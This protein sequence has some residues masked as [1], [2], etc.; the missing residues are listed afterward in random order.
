M[1]AENPTAPHRVTRLSVSVEKSGSAYVSVPFEVPKAAT[2]FDLRY[3]YPKSDNCIIDLGLGDPDLTDFPSKQGLVGWSGG[4]RSAVFIAM[5]DASPGYA[6]GLR[7][8]TWQV[9]LG[10]YR[11]PDHPVT[12]EIEITF[13]PAPREE[14]NRPARPKIAS[15]GPG[16]YRGDLHCHTFHSDAK[17]SPERLHGTALR[18][19]LDFLAVT[20]HNTTTAHMAYFDRASSPDLIFVPGYEFTT[21]Q[22][23]GN[24]FGARTVEDF[25]A[26]TDRDVAAMIARIQ[27]K[28]YLFSVN[29]DKPNI[30]W[31]YPFPGADCM[32]VWHAPW[33]SGN[34]FCLERYQA[35]LSDGQRLTAI[36]GSDLHQPATDD[37]GNLATLARPCTFLYCN[38]LSVEGILDALRNGR[39][40]VTEAPGGPRLLL[41]VGDTIHGGEIRSAPT[42]PLSYQTSGAAGDTLEV[43]DATGCICTTDLTSNSQSGVLPLTAAKGFVRGQIVANA[44]RAALVAAGQ[45]HV[46][47]GKGGR[48]DWSQAWDKPAL[49]ALTSPIYVT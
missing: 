41:S 34:H 5:D 11:L 42:I 43:W 9:L 2:R 36:G 40:F 8:G 4:A 32:E 6:P 26:E 18:E 37:S 44:S 48:L 14:A 12:V 49:R 20:D 3:S 27:A 25:R 23:H 17:G 16:W 28:G 30:P 13:D 38:D 21:A 46:A 22:G 24:I 39:S 7:P 47:A 19:G 1:S 15:S 35:K 31:N 10:L 33:L 29:H 45:A